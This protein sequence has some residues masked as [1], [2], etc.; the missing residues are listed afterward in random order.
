MQTPSIPESAVLVGV[1]LGGSGF[2]VRRARVTCPEPLELEAAGEGVEG[3][4][5]RGFEPVPLEEQLLELEVGGMRLA[6]AE[7][8]AA[9]DRIGLLARAIV[10]GLG[11]PEPGAP[12]LVGIAA[13]GLRLHGE[14]G[15]GVV[16]NGPRIPDLCARLE[17]RL[18]EHQ[19]A[20]ARPLWI[21]SDGLAQ[22]AA[23]RHARGGLLRELQCGSAL[24]GGSGLAEAFVVAG[25]LRAL[26]ELGGMERAWQM[27]DARGLSFEDR[28]APGR[29]NARWEELAREL[30]LDGRERVESA[31]AR[32]VGEARALLADLTRALAQLVRRRAQELERAAPAETLER[33]VLGGALAR[34]LA[35]PEGRTWCASIEA[36]LAEE[37]SAE[38]AAER[39]RRA[40]A[41]ALSVLEHAPALGALALALLR[42]PHLVSGG[43]RRS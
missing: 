23:E 25:R 42:A 9:R 40:P 35:R 15:L 29:V 26:D 36:A 30:G 43:G 34:M 17:Q 24:A 20:L 39:G 14:R 8:R 37:F 16:R 7:T 2:R 18:Q 28:I 13:P 38:R 4:W 19:V 1:D 10:R 41:F 12:A 11:R 31:A 3:A 5:P 6:D 21:A 33:V 27:R 22:A 32:G